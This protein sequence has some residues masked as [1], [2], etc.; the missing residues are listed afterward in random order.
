MAAEIAPGALFCI[1]YGLYIVSSRSGDKLN[2][3]IVN[4]VVQVAA[5]PPK[6]A[7]S[8]N[9][10]NLTHEF[11]SESGVFGVCVL[12]QTTPMTLIGRFGFRSGRDI[13]KFDKVEHKL[14][15]TGVPL[16]TEHVL[17]VLE[18][19][20]IDAVDVGTHTLFVGELLSAEIVGTGDPLT[21]DYYHK[22]LKGKTPKN[23]PS[24]VE[25]Q[26]QA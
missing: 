12:D 14:G 20:V 4:T 15:Q 19:K 6:I 22:Y 2:G 7:V 10:E 23:A 26:T 21:Y 3:Q 8:I 17:S 18:A 13:D 24:Y 1:S 16:V 5:S 11:I 25:T 9:K